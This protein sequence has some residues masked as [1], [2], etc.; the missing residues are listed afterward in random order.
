MI[1]S[2]T[3]LFRYAPTLESP[4][5]L[6]SISCPVELMGIYALGPGGRVSR[7]YGLRITSGFCFEQHDG[8]FLGADRFDP[9]DPDCLA[10]LLA[11]DL[12]SRALLHVALA[13]HLARFERLAARFLGELA[14]ARP[15]ERHALRAYS[16]VTWQ[17]QYAEVDLDFWIDQ[18]RVET[19]DEDLECPGTWLY[20]S[21]SAASFD[22][23]FCV[24]DTDLDR[25]ND[26]ASQARRTA[27]LPVCSRYGPEVEELLRD[28]GAALEE[29]FT[30]VL[31][32]V[33]ATS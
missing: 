21:L 27:C 23:V 9:S 7:F 20:Y 29:V 12:G 10:T 1:R 11:I 31:R 28:N 15:D 3:N 2:T 16:S 26:P 19:Q 14:A 4:E 30:T 25:P 18:D 17:P 24:R 5:P 13:E 22:G 33:E 6:D 32:K 8:R